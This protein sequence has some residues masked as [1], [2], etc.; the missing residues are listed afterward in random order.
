MQIWVL[1]ASYIISGKK[2]PPI[3]A[4]LTI[5]LV[6]NESKHNSAGSW[7]ARFCLLEPL[8]KNFMSIKEVDAAVRDS[9]S[10]RLWASLC[11]QHLSLT[12]WVGCVIIM[13]WL[14][15][16]L[17]IS[18]SSYDVWRGLLIASHSE[19]FYSSPKDIVTMIRKS[20]ILLAEAGRR[21]LLAPQPLHQ[22]RLLEE[23]QESDYCE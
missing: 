8:S 22:W 1:S 3:I 15:W 16:K 2:G 5:S 13:Q 17:S 6:M 11:E 19:I 7:I 12:W 18:I 20:H 21:F 9:R 14:I 10:V 23:K 4:L